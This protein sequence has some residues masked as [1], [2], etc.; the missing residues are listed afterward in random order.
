[1]ETKTVKLTKLEWDIV[2]D[3]AQSEFSSDGHGLQ[4]YIDHRC[5]DMKIYR[6][7][8]ASLTNKGV[9]TFVAQ[10][11][12]DNCTWGYIQGDY[13]EEVGREN[14]KGYTRTEQWLIKDTGHRLVNLK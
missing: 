3:I 4:G 14:Y 6:G 13:E 7:V 9:A 12:S 2:N 11:E 5:Y 10:E 1:M 8:M